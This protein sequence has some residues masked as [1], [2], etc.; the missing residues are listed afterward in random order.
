MK[1]L[2]VVTQK[3]GTRT[4]TDGYDFGQREKCTS[5]ILKCKVLRNQERQHKWNN[6]VY[7]KRCWH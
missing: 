5:W 1:E 6:K 4:K 7:K 3:F 2:R